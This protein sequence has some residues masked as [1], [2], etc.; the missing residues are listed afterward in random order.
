MR[1]CAGLLCLHADD[2]HPVAQDALS[3]RLRADLDYIRKIANQAFRDD[4]VYVE[5]AEIEQINCIIG[6]QGFLAD[7]SEI[8]CIRVESPG[9]LHQLLVVEIAG[10]VFDCLWKRQNGDWNRPAL[11]ILSGFCPGQAGRDDDVAWVEV[12]LK[13]PQIISGIVLRGM[14]VID[15]KDCERADHPDE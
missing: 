10:V 2:P 15:L 12:G 11:E 14:V 4:P 13:F 6:P 9:V 8:L 1:A 3:K 7:L 5:R